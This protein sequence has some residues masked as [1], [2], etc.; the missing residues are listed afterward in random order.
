MAYN[1]LLSKRIHNILT[2][3][4]IPFEEKKM[5]GGIAFMIKDKMACGVVKNDLMFRVI[6]NRY[7]TL[8]KDENL[9]PMDFTGKPLR[10]FIYAD[11]AATDTD[12]QLKYLINFSVEF[13]DTENPKPK[14]KAK[15]KSVK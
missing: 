7:E 4:G 8:L 11:E 10:G 15:T 1:E 5:F 9:R 13:V 2:A 3:Q 6:E 14:K 12:S